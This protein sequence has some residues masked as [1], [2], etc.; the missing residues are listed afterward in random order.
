M[1]FKYIFFIAITTLILRVDLL[2][3]N[4]D[5]K[6]PCKSY[7]QLMTMDCQEGKERCYVKDKKIFP[8]KEYFCGKGI[9][10]YKNWLCSKAKI[11]VTA[12]NLNNVVCNKTEE[13]SK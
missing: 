5:K 12:D 7:P 6:N 4:D 3:A 2:I 10:K 11:K 1:N 13:K 9:L 8:K